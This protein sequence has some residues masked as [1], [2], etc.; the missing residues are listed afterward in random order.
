MY[1]GGSEKGG[2]DSIVS[3]VF[4]D[5]D[6]SLVLP[7]LKWNTL[8]LHATD[9]RGPSL[10]Y[11]TFDTTYG[12]LHH[13]FTSYF[14]LRALLSVDSSQQNRCTTIMAATSTKKWA[15]LQ[16]LVSIAFAVR[17]PNTLTCLSP[18]YLITN[19]HSH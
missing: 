19:V 5:G 15:Y 10:P 4:G 13:L 1:Q 6:G 8:R 17:L 3:L 18:K 11:P 9:S 16:D 14:T 2:H 7:R 12:Y